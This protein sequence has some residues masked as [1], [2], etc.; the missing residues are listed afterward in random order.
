MC[1]EPQGGWL[2]LP[3]A[4]STPGP[5][6]PPPLQ[7]MDSPGQGGPSF[8]HHCTGRHRPRGKPSQSAACTRVPHLAERLQVWTGGERAVLQ[9]PLTLLVP[10]LPLE[11]QLCQ[12]LCVTRLRERRSDTPSPHKPVRFPNEPIPTRQRSRAAPTYTENGH[13]PHQVPQGPA[14]GC[15]G[16]VGISFL[17]EHLPGLIQPALQ[18]QDGHL[19]AQRTG[20]FAGG[21]EANPSTATAA[22]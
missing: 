3:V 18:H 14:Q 19:G 5:K 20:A 10:V 15:G 2:S 11:L 9:V 21:L 7:R 6:A 1:A 12:G 17:G 8:C 16:G 13:C 22:S 4:T